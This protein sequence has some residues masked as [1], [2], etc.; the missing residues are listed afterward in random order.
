MPIGKPHRRPLL[1]YERQIIDL[2]G[3]T[4]EEYQ[5]FMDEVIRQ[6]LVKPAGYEHIPEIRCDPATISFVVSFVVGIAV[7][8]VSYLLAPKPAAL[9]DTKSGQRTLASRSGA[10]RY[11]QTTGFDSTAELAQ[12]GEAIP[13]VWTKWTGTTGGVLVSPK[14]VWSRMFSLGGQ[15]GIKLLYV[16]GEAGVGAPDLAGIYLG[17]NGLDVI[18]RNSFALWWNNAGKVSRS[19]LLYGTQGGQAAGDPQDTTDLFFTPAGVESFSQ[20]LSPSNSTQFGVSNPMPNGTQ[21]RLNYRIVSIPEDAEGKGA[22]RRDRAKICGADFSAKNEANIYPQ[23]G[24]GI[25]YFR[26]QGING[27]S[28]KTSFTASVG[29][30]I[31]YIISGEQIDDYFWGGRTS[32]VGGGKMDDV[33]NTLDSE[34]AATDDA[35]QLGETVIINASVWRVV[36]RSLPVWRR[37]RTQLITLECIEVLDLADVRVLG[38][39]QLTSPAGNSPGL[40]N[41]LNPN[42]N[43]GPIYDNLAR[44]SFATIKNTR[45]C[46]FTQIGI[47]SQVWGRFNG[48]CNFNSLYSRNHIKEL[49]KQNVSVQSGT[50]SEYFPRASVFTLYFRE[51][52]QTTWTRTAL[53][54]CV[55]GSSP[56]DQ[57]HT[58]G[59]RHGSRR[60]LEFRIVPLSAAHVYRLGTSAQLWQLNA[61]LPNVELGGN[62]VIIRVQAEITTV[63]ACAQL[64]TMKTT[65]NDG[66]IRNFDVATGI[67]EISNY[68]GLIN[69]S[70][71]N[72]PE[73]QVVFLNEQ[74]ATN[75]V[76]TFES[77]TT[78]ALA[79]RSGRN[80]SSIDQLRL[81]IS[82]GI[83][84]SNSFPDLILYLLQR[85]NGVSGELIDSASFASAAAYCASRGLF[86]DGAISERINLRQYIADTAPFFLLNFV[87]ANGKFSLMPALPDGLPNISNLFTA[88]NIIEGSFSVEYLAA[89][90]RR[91]FQALVTYRSHLKKNELPV[92][93]TYRARF[94]STPLNAPIESFDMSAYCTSRQHAEQVARYFLSIRRRITHAIKFKTAHEGVGIAPGS[95][96]KVALEQNVI[97][98][99]GN[100]VISASDGRVTSATPLSDGTYPITYYKAGAQDVQTA[101]MT[102][103]NGAAADSQLWGALF[104]RTNSSIS[105]S[106]YLVEQIE[107][108]DDGLVNVTATEFPAEAI[109]SDMAGVG[110]V[111]EET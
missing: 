30:R 75:P 76:P 14:L 79:A 56:V 35:L 95:Y 104:T 48:L 55:R 37:K 92:L 11:A 57:F 99:Y 89:D 78:V 34:C 43:A 73:H 49:D 68:G 52:G 19:N 71:D 109:T 74:L 53:N 65:D 103:T 51:I 84:N 2:A 77:L 40:P 4:V 46:D 69:R 36:N 96:I 20:A 86:F 18:S 67:A 7:S 26:R 58:L 61:N 50:M 22:L 102:I 64:E 94:E 24:V 80:I 17:N 29:A 93:R 82:S 6:S 13:I 60:A 108:D 97:S 88:G 44:V 107:L 59:V 72:G 41:Q 63:G 38:S 110:I 3:C 81:W 42:V 111:A 100:G 8:A 90:Q 62:G 33:N 16:V 1:P 9:S 91:D 87:I 10:D 83:N 32:K 5:H 101:S 31:E 85:A 105:A 23:D 39:R 21:Y 66:P 98:S 15:Q 28:S 45:P 47:K 106:T 27:F 54:F 70:C 12:Y 25:G